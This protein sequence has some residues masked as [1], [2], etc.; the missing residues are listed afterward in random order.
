MVCLTRETLAL[1]FYA[2]LMMDIDIRVFARF[3]PK[4]FSRENRSKKKKAGTKRRR[5]LRPKIF[6]FQKHSLSFP[7][8]T[9]DN[10]PKQEV[11]KGR[12]R[13]AICTTKARNWRAR[14]QQNRSQVGQ[15]CT[16]ETLSR[17]R[18]QEFWSPVSQEVR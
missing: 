1:N 8:E 4:N 11:G 12:R 16:S 18:V 9:S 3:P 13:K 17:A 14:S 15:S 2:I 6:F 5:F 7:F 10:G